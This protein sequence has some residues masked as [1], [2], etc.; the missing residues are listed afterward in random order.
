MNR[1]MRSGRAKRA[2]ARAVAVGS[3]RQ[4]LAAFMIALDEWCGPWPAGTIS[5]RDA[6]RYRREGMAPENAARYHFGTV[7]DTDYFL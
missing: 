6:L 7:L 1:H 5:D 4:W 2:A 3:E